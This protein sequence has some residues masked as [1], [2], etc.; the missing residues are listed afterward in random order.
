MA[1]LKYGN[2]SL[3]QAS[4][5]P[6][7]WTDRVYKDACTGNQCKLK[8]AKKVVAKYSPD[9]YLLSH[10]TII[11]SVD[12]DLAD[13]K[14]PKSG[15]LIKPEFS[16][17]INNNGDAWTK[18]VL[19][20]SYRSFIGGENYLEHV[21]IPEL[22][23]GKIIDAVPREIVIGKD[24]EGKEL[25]SL[26]IDILVATNRKH[27]EL[28]RQIQSNE[29]N[30]LSMGCMIKYS[31]CSRCGNRA[32]DD[33]EACN[34]VRFQK[35]NTFFDDNGV[36]RKVAELCGHDT[37]P[38]SVKFIEASWVRQPA[39]TGAVLR[40][41]VTP[42]EV[43][44][45]KIEKA[46]SVESYSI[47]ENA[48]LKVAA[49]KGLIAADPKD[50]DKEQDKETPPPPPDDVPEDS[51][52]SAPDDAPVEDT[53][54]TA[55]DA[56]PD[57]IPE[58]APD[59]S[60]VPD[61]PVPEEDSIKVFKKDL[62]K[63]VLDQIEDEVLEDLSEEEEKGP[64]DLETLDETLIRPASVILS[65]V[66]ASQKSFNNL[67][68]DSLKNSSGKINKKAYDK[69]RYGVHM[70]LTN[71]DLTSLKDYG[72]SKRDFLA[73]LSFIDEKY[74]KPLPLR[75]K[76]I[77]ANLGGTRGKQP[78]ENLREVVARLGRPVTKREAAKIISWLRILDFYS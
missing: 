23:K 74:V 9:K 33:T 75:A 36:Q 26:Y 78:V 65:K 73:V 32:V 64:R 53:E 15:Y 62:K 70:A 3:V 10:V 45:S 68:K 76:Q 47:Q 66:W 5:A 22:S 4:V 2:A 25:T 28:V 21:Q 41:F 40:S 48:F 7:D 60:D 61:V 51:T 17:L 63:K 14:D 18:Q 71:N 35:N 77:I 43:I 54:D 52:E 49:E 13:P 12:T 58:D 55:T 6:N 37:E 67:I 16:K 27:D 56:P 31:I 34:H 24:K 29:L 38:D 42:S 8:T 1:M 57:D 44:S 19:I 59:N 39:F 69:L 30:S 11:A 20:N 72:Y 46:H 50:E